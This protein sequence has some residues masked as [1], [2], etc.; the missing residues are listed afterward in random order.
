MLETWEMFKIFLNYN[1][2]LWSLV[3]GVAFSVLLDM[4]SMIEKSGI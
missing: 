3:H 2:N 4:Q 1:G